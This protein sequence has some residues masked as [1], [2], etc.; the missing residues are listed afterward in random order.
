MTLIRSATGADIPFIMGTERM[1]GYE[2][3]VGRWDEALHRR[4]MGRPETRYFI[5]EREG[6]PFG[7]AILRD[8]DD[9]F[10]NVLLKRIAVREPGRGLG[11][12][13][14]HAVL[15]TAFDLP[16]PYRIW[17]K[18]APHN[19]RAR[20]LYGSLGFVEEGVNRESHVDPA[21]QRVSAVVMSILR[22]EWR[23]DPA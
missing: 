19:E 12:S 22:R 13:L 7:F 15:A 23:T 18:V 21:G 9:A 8:L 16:Q 6:V 4:E 17:L 1:P 11:R 20:R 14:L 10:G 2:W 3:V 5:G